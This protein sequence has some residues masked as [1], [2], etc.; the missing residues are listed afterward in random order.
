MTGTSRGETSQRQSLEDLPYE[1]ILLI[2][3]NIRQPSAVYSFIRSSPI[4]YKVF[5][6]KK[7]AVL[8][9]TI[10]GCFHPAVLP[11]A[12]AVCDV[13]H[14]LGFSV[15]SLARAIARRDEKDTDETDSDASSRS[16]REFISRKQRIDRFWDDFRDQSGEDGLSISERL[17]DMSLASSLFRLYRVTEFFICDYLKEEFENSFWSCSIGKSYHPQSALPGSADLRL[18]DSEYGRLQRGFLLYEALSHVSGGV[19]RLFDLTDA[20]AEDVLPSP[21]ITLYFFS[22][23]TK[24]ETL[25][26]E[27]VQFYVYC[28]VRKVI[29]EICDFLIPFVEVATSDKLTAEYHR[30]ADDSNL[31][32]AYLLFRGPSRQGR[33]VKAFLALLGLPFVRFFKK[34]EKEERLAIAELCGRQWCVSTLEEEL[35]KSII[36]VEKRP[37]DGEPYKHSQVGGEEDDQIARVTIFVSHRANESRID[38]LSR[39]GKRFESREQQRIHDDEDAYMEFGFIFWDDARVNDVSPEQLKEEFLQPSLCGK[40][41]EGFPTGSMV[42]EAA[43]VAAGGFRKMEMAELVSLVEGRRY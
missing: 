38:E 11:L 9:D 10:R 42:N 6:A 12:I 35:K 31:P 4:I 29:N 20:L 39:E 40:T 7:P 28:H 21:L 23:L 1:I 3:E 43:L 26:L 14:D 19:L 32:Y 16:I 37:G 34:L 5:E 13:S 41:P 8:A 27:A 2:L 17:Q 30:T 18:S 22:Q 15:R 36:Y 25:E 24:Q 33:S